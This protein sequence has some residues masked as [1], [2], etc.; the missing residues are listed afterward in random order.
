MKTKKGFKN[1]RHISV[2]SELTEHCPQHI[3]QPPFIADDVD[4]RCNDDDDVVHSHR[5]RASAPVSSVRHHP[6]IITITLFT[7][8]IVGTNAQYRPS[9]PSPLLQREI[10][11]LNLEDGYFG[12]QVNESTDFLQLFELSKLCDGIPQCFQASDEDPQALKCTDRSE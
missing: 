1:R 12:C 2:M 9:W 11:V 8:L 3:R 6:L 5:Y 7:L 4:A 10:F